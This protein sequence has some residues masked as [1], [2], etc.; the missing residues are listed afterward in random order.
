M[1]GMV[2]SVPSAARLRA[3]RRSPHTPI[4]ARGA[5]GRQFSRLVLLGD[6]VDLEDFDGVLMIRL[7]R[8]DAHDDLVTTLDRLLI[9][10]AG[11]GDFAL[12]KARFD[13]RDHA[14]HLVDA[15][16]VVT[17]GALQYPASDAPGNSCRRADRQRQ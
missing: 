1:N 5:Q 13:G 12:R 10:V 2:F 14:A 8:V 11:V 15:A 3:S 9:L 16:D 7:K 6:L 4:I 17:R